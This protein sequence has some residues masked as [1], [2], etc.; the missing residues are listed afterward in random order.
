M[1]ASCS[2][3]SWEPADVPVGFLL[4]GLRLWGSQPG[5]VH[6]NLLFMV[7]C[8]GIMAFVYV[9]AELVI[10]EAESD[11]VNSAHDEARRTSPVRVMYEGDCLCCWEGVFLPRRDLGGPLYLTRRQK[12]CACVAR[13]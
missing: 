6:P 7:F 8:P 5:L 10:A 3:K 4:S 1:L 12:V 9:P 13:G 2:L 11:A